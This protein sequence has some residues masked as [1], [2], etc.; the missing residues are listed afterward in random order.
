MRPRG[1]SR[2]DQG[3][4][5]GFP[6]D[7][8]SRNSKLQAPSSRE[9]PSSKLQT[10][11]V[12]VLELEVWSFCG[13]WSLGFGVFHTS[14]YTLSLPFSVPLR[15]PRA[16]SQFRTASGSQRRLSFSVF[17]TRISTGY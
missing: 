2:A 3:L 17:G 6:G 5:A 15:N 12:L 14:L 11:A 8:D 1:E 16:H 7:I 13:V 10:P 9:T 4:D